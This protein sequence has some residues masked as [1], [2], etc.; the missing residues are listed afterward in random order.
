M[1]AGGNRPLI[2]VVSDRRMQG[3]HAFH[4]VGEKYLQ[5]LADGSDANPVAL[6]SLA[7]GFDVLDIIDRLDGLFLTGSPSNLEPHHYLGE[8]SVPGTW[9]DPER[10]LAAL[11][12]IPAVIRAGMPLFA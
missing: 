6:P 4:M 1:I 7:E 5:A 9:H 2:G 12:L 11:A 3:E 8:A 10:D